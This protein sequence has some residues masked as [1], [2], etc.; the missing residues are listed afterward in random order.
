MQLE[1]LGSWLKSGVSGSI[2]AIL[3]TWFLWNTMQ[4][5]KAEII[6]VRKDFRAEIAEVRKDIKLVDEK[7]DERMLE[8]LQYHSGATS[9]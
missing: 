9:V 6:E 1:D 8:H 4:G 5:I 2:I 7:I 3:A